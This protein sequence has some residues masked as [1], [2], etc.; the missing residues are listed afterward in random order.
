MADNITTMSSGLNFVS[1]LYR[2]N[3]YNGCIKYRNSRN[4]DDN[5]LMPKE[6]KTNTI[7]IVLH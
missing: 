3:K 1:N 2:L 5:Y 4:K 6:N 7:F